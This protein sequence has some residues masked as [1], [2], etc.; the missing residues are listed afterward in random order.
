MRKKLLLSTAVLLASVG[1]ATAQTAPG[2]QPR[3]HKQSAQP[4]G[5]EMRQGAQSPQ[6][7]TTGQGQVG[8]A[9]KQPERLNQP[10]STQNMQRSGTSE[11]TQ[12]GQREHNQ[13]T[14]QGMGERNQPSGQAAKERNQPSSQATGER[15][16]TTGQAQQPS[17]KSPQTTGQAQQ[18][19]AQSPQTQ[20]QPNER[21]AQPSQAQPSQA[22]SRQGSSAQVQQSQASGTVNLTTEQRTK[23]Q[24][25]VLASRDVPRVDH[26]TF[27]LAVG[28]AV[29]A[30]I[31][32]VEVPETL[33]E[34]H[35]EWRGDMYF[36][37]R[38]EI[39]IVD[40]S[41]NIVAVLPVGSS[42]AAVGTRGPMAS[43][44]GTMSVDEIRQVQIMLNQKGFNVGEPD[45]VLGPRT[46]EALI[47]FQR[48]QG[49]E[50]S[51]QIDSRT[52]SALGVSSTQQQQGA[53]GRPATVGSQPSPTAQPGAGQST[54]SPSTA[55]PSTAGQGSTMQ[56]SPTTGS[57]A[58]QMN[59]GAGTAP[60]TTAPNA[61]TSAPKTSSPSR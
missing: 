20:A 13:T 9:Q 56:H 46:R 26:V 50:A 43:G 33:I 36:V 51:G 61:G 14:G 59:T 2:A 30:T 25:T 32:V 48:Q 28:T 53:Q 11:R 7:Q 17:S 1:L 55:A 10:Q 16:R 47:A 22:Q 42:S 44:S 21:A 23:I 31:R 39:I 34:I 19:H 38:D 3:E 18:P 8:Q 54:A 6:H 5:G 60:Q 57:G 24:Q 27:S 15:S 40:H 49:F 58:G 35:P 45:G 29:P 12:A 52:M 37:V 41:R 4:S